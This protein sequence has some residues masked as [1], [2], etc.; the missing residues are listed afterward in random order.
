VPQLEGDRAGDIRIVSLR[1][2]SWV[3]LIPLSETVTSVGVVVPWA[4]RE[5]RDRAPGGIL[6]GT[7][8]SIPSLAPLFESAER[9]VPVRRDADFSYSPSRYAGDGWLLA[10]DAGSFLDPVFSTGVLLALKSGREAAGAAVRGLDRGDLSARGLAPYDRTQRSTYRHFRRMV[11]AFYD[12]AFRDVLFRPSNRLGLL[13]AVIT[14]LAGVSKPR[15]VTRLRLSLFFLVVG[16]HRRFGLGERIH[17]LPE[18]EK[19]SA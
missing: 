17:R 3:W 1:D 2:M 16:L 15:P 11:A 7:L 4:H 12:P 8:R 6:E 13:E 5:R 18:L 10:G 19:A 9:L 14:T